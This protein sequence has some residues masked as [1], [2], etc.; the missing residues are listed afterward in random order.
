[1]MAE[2]YSPACYVLKE[3]NDNAIICK[4]KCGYHSCGEGRFK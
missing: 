1:M 4:L 2:M 3:F